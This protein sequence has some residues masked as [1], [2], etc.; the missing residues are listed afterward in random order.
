MFVLRKDTT[1]IVEWTCLWSGAWDTCCGLIDCRIV[2]LFVL[3]LFQQRTSF[4]SIQAPQTR[5]KMVCGLDNTICDIS[6]QNQSKLPT[7]H[8]D[9]FRWYKTVLIHLRPPYPRRT[10]LRPSWGHTGR[11]KTVPSALQYHRGSDG[12]CYRQIRR[13]FSVLSCLSCDGLS[14]QKMHTVLFLYCFV[15]FQDLLG[16]LTYRPSDLRSS[17]FVTRPP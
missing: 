11:K 3:Q 12:R 2:G 16:K 14:Q 6:G 10:R 7:K 4:V 8:K 5:I 13:S 9:G 15:L 1:F 17:T